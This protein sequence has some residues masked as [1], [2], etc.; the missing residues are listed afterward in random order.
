M[1]KKKKA[2][3]PRLVSLIIYCP[4]IDKEVQVEKSDVIW[5]PEQTECEMCGSHGKLKFEF[6]CECGAGHTVEVY[7]W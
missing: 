6:T 4:T 5:Y 3:P 7:D 2:L 1:A